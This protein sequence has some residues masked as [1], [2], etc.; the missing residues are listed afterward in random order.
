[1]DWIIWAFAVG[2]LLIFIGAVWF[3]FSSGYQVISDLD[4]SW[5]DPTDKGPK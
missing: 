2:V 3:A 4:T 1:M 5:A